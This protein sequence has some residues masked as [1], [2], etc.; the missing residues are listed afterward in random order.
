MMDRR[1]SRKLLVGVGA[2][3]GACVA[4]S[5]C[6]STGGSGGLAQPPAA[7]VAAR[8]PAPAAP[9]PARSGGDITRVSHTAPA[10]APRTVLNWT[11]TPVPGQPGQK[12]TGQSPVG[13]DGT[14]L[15]GPYGSVRVAGLTLD[16]ARAAVE[17]HLRSYLRS[18]R[19]TL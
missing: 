7:S 1:A 8:A 11:I 18:P 12:M 13:P 19:L 6:Q 4:G 17:R 15:L 3:L 14:L 2:L 5:G 16:Q 10:I 9:P